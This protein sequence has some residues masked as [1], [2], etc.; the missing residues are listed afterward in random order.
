MTSLTSKIIEHPSTALWVFHCK[1]NFA[2]RSL[3][4]FFTLPPFSPLT[5]LYITHIYQSSFLSLLRST[6][7]HK[8]YLLSSA[9]C[10]IQSPQSRLYLGSPLRSSH[11]SGNLFSTGTVL[12]VI[13]SQLSRIWNLILYQFSSHHHWT[14]LFTVSIPSLGFCKDIPPCHVTVEPTELP[15]LSAWQLRGKVRYLWIISKLIE[16][17]H[18]LLTNTIAKPVKK[19]SSLN[20]TITF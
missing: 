15:A 7:N 4:L 14:Q 18:F 16:K 8:R 9:I 3:I 19:Y 13:R 20:H 5:Q 17:R 10:K 1:S 2:G 6:K 12:H 11:G